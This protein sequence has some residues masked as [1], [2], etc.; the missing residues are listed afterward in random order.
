M[1]YKPFFSFPEKGC[2]LHQHSDPGKGILM[3]HYFIL[4]MVL[5]ASVTLYATI[6]GGI[7]PRGNRFIQDL[8]NFFS[9]L[10]NG[11]I[12]LTQSFNPNRQGKGLFEQI[13]THL[14]TF[15]NGLREI[16]I[17]VSQTGLSV[18]G[19]S[20]SMKEHA[21]KMRNLAD[22]TSNQ[23]MQVATAME[24]MSA[25]IT[26]IARNI[27]SA[28]SASVEMR[29]DVNVAETEIQESIGSIQDLSEDIRDWA[30]TNRALSEGTE[31]I[32]GIIS[33]INDIAD[34]TNLLALNAAIEA[35]RAGENGRGFAVVAEEVRKLADKTG[36]ATQE[37]SDMVAEIGTQSNTALKTM[38]KT[39]QS[40]SET[41]ERGAGGY[42]AAENPQRSSPGGR[43]DGPGSS[44]GGRTE[45]SGRKRSRQY[46]RCLS[47]CRGDPLCRRRDFTIIGYH[48]KACRRT[49][50]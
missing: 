36:K 29:T 12:D 17:N 43:H 26:D 13:G 44:G 32:S 28:A 39:L 23:A 42:S 19:I 25:T 34:Q 4:L 14:N 45:F 2:Q 7:S 31:Q 11:R 21:A 47:F 1:S 24:E 48:C 49:L 50:Q 18:I 20:D 15:I 10:F 16:V 27:N 8:Q 5:A 41:R 3:M 6:K 30:E 46:E 40:I 33:V 38:D 22:E 37:I 9:N 35:A